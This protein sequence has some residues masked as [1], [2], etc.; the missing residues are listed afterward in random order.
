V[1]RLAGLLGGSDRYS[2]P[3]TVEQAR[4]YVERLVRR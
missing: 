3:L 1:T 2:L 4:I